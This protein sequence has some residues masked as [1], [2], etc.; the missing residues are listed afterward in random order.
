MDSQACVVVPVH[1]RLR[2]SL[3]R[4]P[5]TQ[6]RAA[7]THLPQDKLADAK[8]EAQNH[9]IDNIDQ[10]QTGGVIPVNRQGIE[11]LNV[12][13]KNINLPLHSVLE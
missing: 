6:T 2:L 9:N 11:E 7:R 12:I 13:Y 1:Q 4:L 3:L 5:L 10:Q 8:V